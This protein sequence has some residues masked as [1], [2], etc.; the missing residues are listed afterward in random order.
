[1]ARLSDAIEAFIKELLEDAKEREIEIQRNELASQFSCAPSQINYVLT[2]RFTQDKG[3]YIES[4]RGGGGCIKITRIHYATYNSLAEIINDKIGDYIT[5]DSA[6]KI[7]DSLRE[8][9]IVTDR[10][11]GII[12][13][14]INDRT[15]SYAFENKNRLRADILKTIILNI[16]K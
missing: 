7:I 8:S 9:Q 3:Y 15:L 6:N 10:E 4:R 11:A 14:A 1:M 16:L 12:K 5:S 2:T 13:A